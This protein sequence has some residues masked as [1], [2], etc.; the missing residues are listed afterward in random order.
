[1]L[2]RSGVTTPSESATRSCSTSWKN[3]DHHRRRAVLRRREPVPIAIHHDDA[4]RRL[5]ESRSGARAPD[6][7]KNPIATEIVSATVFYPAE[8]Y[9]QD[10]YKK[11]PLRYRYYR[12]GC[13]RDERLRELWGA[14]P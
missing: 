11:N 3:V 10:Y 8:D 7:L 14:T 2:R 4:Q 13:G 9:H 5:A 6:R 12:A 1:M